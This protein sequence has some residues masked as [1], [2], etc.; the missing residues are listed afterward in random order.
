MQQAVQS[1]EAVPY[2][3]NL[4]TKSDDE[5]V[6]M[7]FNILAARARS[8]VVFNSPNIAREYLVLRAAND[9]DTTIEKFAVAFLDSQNRLIDVD[10]MFTGTINQTSVYPREVVRKA[11]AK[12]AAAVILTHN[13]PSGEA[14]PSRADE[15]LT[16]TL[17]AA[18][19]LVDVRVLDHIITT[20]CGKACS[21]AE[22]GLV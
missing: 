1:V 9:E 19:A 21:M 5:I 4:A 8:G 14:R 20:P 13:H 15:N 18:L 16:Q 6:L 12:G 11:L 3:N 17:K 10:T 2:T 22:L 7:A